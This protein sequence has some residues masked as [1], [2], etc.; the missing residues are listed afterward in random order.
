MNVIK[1]L[2]SASVLL[3]TIF[4]SISIAGA[5]SN[6]SEELTF[7]DII[8][9]LPIEQY[10]LKELLTASLDAGKKGETE[11]FLKSE[12]GQKL[13]SYLKE[14]PKLT[15]DIIKSTELYKAMFVNP[16]PG[17][18]EKLK[19]DGK[20]IFDDGSSVT[21][22]QTT[23]VITANSYPSGYG[24]KVYETNN[25]YVYDFKVGTVTPNLKTRYQL[26]RD[27]QAV[28]VTQILPTVKTFGVGVSGSYNAD[29]V[30]EYNDSSKAYTQCSFTVGAEFSGGTNYNNVFFKTSFSNQTPVHE[31]D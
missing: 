31:H 1:R 2:I 7:Q 6:S 15:E 4:L 22:K 28:Y 26:H 9:N 10:E 14:N 13:T 17:V 12:Q 21:L 18:A 16:K 5:S 8:N 29:G 3:L 11:E 25:T 23:N 20:V 30:I 27:G 19:K 24:T